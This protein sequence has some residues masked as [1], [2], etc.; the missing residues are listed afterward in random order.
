MK[1]VIHFLIIFSDEPDPLFGNF[2]IV[3]S[4]LLFSFMFIAEEK[5]LKN[6]EIEVIDA[7]TW[8]GVWGSIFCAIL[9]ILFSHTQT[10]V[11][12][13]FLESCS[14]IY[15]NPNL[16]LAIMCT[17]LVIGPFNYFGMSITK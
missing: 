1:D 2:L 17:F 13:D 14:L 4:Q 11:K 6:F 10:I 3:L 7:V 5:L 8:E 16:L 15:E 9:L 12:C